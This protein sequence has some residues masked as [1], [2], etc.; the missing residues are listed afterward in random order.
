MT[1]RLLRRFR[2]AKI[3]RVYRRVAAGHQNLAIL[4]ISAGTLIRIPQ[5][6][7]VLG[8]SNDFRKTQTAF[9]ARKFFRE[10]IDL[11]SYPLPVFGSA[12]GVHYEMPIFQAGAALI[13]HLGVS[14]DAS[15]QLLSLIMF[16]LASV[17]LASLQKMVR[18]QSCAHLRYP[19]AIH[20]ILNGV[21]IRIPN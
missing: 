11:F 7:F 1:C 19:A 9:V 13:Q 4:T 17:Y 16:Q 15:G 21:G 5:L 12:Q 20:S 2:N 6:G 14:E 10:G 18:R 3:S 8:D